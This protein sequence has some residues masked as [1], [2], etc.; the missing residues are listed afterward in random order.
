LRRLGPGI[1][2][3]SST[4]AG[5]LSAMPTASGFLHRQVRALFEIRDPAA[6][7]YRPAVRSVLRLVT[8][9]PI[10]AVLSSV[11]PY[12]AHLVGRHLRK[13]FGI[14]WLADF[15][16]PWSQNLVRQALPGWRRW[17]DRRMESSCLRWADR[18]I[19]NT[20]RLRAAF[21]RL[22]PELPA[23]KFLTL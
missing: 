7:W 10:A 21:N 19:C 11:P 4:P 15:R 13:R 16:D 17:I 3:G 5:S 14:P 20:D 8:A 12:T 6:A 18:V 23:D 9:E 2:E 22:H 1:G